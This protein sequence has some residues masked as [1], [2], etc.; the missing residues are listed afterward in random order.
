M[1]YE[2][3]QDQLEFQLALAPPSFSALCYCLLTATEQLVEQ[4]VEQAEKLEEGA[5]GESTSS[6]DGNGSREGSES[7]ESS[8]HPAFNKHGNL[9]IFFD[10]WY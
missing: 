1:A 7:G 6:Q 9:V 8:K 5:S 3:V 2:A 10:S 4:M